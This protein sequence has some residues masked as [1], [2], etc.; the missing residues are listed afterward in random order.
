MKLA[1]FSFLLAL[2]SLSQA[3]SELGKAY[4]NLHSSENLSPQQ[5]LKNHSDGS[6]E[7]AR[8]QDE[9]TADLQE[10]IQ[11][12]TNEKVVTL[13]TES[14]SLMNLA[15]DKLTR[16]DT[17]AATIAIPTEI[18]EK[19]AAAAKEKS[20]SSSSEKK[21]NQALLQMMQQMMGESPSDAP[22]KENGKGAG[23]GGEGADGASDAAA[24]AT[25]GESKGNKESR[26]L[27]KSSGSA[28]TT[29]PLEFHKALE[30]YNKAQDK[31]Q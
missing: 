5:Q 22:P 24:Q 27:A 7:I 14:E 29:L 18:I 30:A 4:Q 21:G 13:L 28:G 8:I 25:T 10:L 6:G 12:E 26:R 15:T 9:L 1:I 17:S 16:A 23:N 3:E 20:Q 11:E 31:S 2:I 19:I